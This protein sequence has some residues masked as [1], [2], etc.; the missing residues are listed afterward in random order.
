[1]PKNP[2]PCL[3]FSRPVPLERLGR[4]AIVEEISATATERAALARRFGLLGL[5]RFAAMLR[6]GAAD[7]G[8]LIRVDGHLSADATQA[9]VVTLVPVASR[10]EEDFC[11][12]YSLEA[13]PSVVEAGEVV[14]EPEGEGPPEPLGGAGIDLGEI[15]A[16]Q[17]ALALDPYPRAPGAASAEPGEEGTGPEP[18]AEGTFAVLR[19]LKIGG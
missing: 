8:G 2:E 19:S 3:E 15:V 16:Q 10:V 12:L 13:G 1:M 7:G 4:N 6:I 14:V 18:A 5:D 11:L 17:L 9:C